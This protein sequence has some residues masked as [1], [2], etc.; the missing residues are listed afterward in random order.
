MSFFTTLHSDIKRVETETAAALSKVASV[1]A[2]VAGNTT[3]QTVVEGVSATLFGQNTANLEAVGF[4]LLSQLGQALDK[5]EA[6]FE[7][8]LANLGVD[9]AAIAAFKSLW[10]NIKAQSAAKPVVPAK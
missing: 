3:L 1:I 10:T 2:K 8:N 5:S 6:A 9:Q 4:N 7:S